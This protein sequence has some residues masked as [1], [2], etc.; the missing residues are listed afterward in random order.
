MA[1]SVACANDTMSDSRRPAAPS[2]SN[3]ARR[4]AVSADRLG[5]YRLLASLPALGSYRAKFV[6]VV[7][8]G[9]FVPAFLLVLAIVL[10]AGRLGLLAVIALVVSFAVLGFALVVRAIDRLLAPLD[11]A[12][13]AVDDLAFGRGVTRVDVPGSDTAAQVLRGVQGLAQRVE[14][15]AQ[16]SRTRGERDELTGLLNRG[17]GRERAQQLIDGE[18]RRG[19]CVRVVVAD[20][21]AFA[22]FN[23]RHGSGH[24]DAMLKVIASRIARVAG[25]DAVAARWGGDAFM[26]AQSGPPDDMPDAQE[27]LGR[28]I[29]VKGTDEPLRLM[30]GIAQTQSRVPLDQLVAEA[31]AALAAARSRR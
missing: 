29:V 8:A 15:D 1:T 20:V 16:G 4:E 17:I 26:L 7:A 18:T 31:E 5:F 14:R 24:G 2:A 13:A 25:D 30:L 21:V 27:L 9:F 19:R 6:A 28:P 10:G 3:A 23:A 22:A 11:A 12:E